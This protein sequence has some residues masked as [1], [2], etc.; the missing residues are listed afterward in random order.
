MINCEEISLA[1]PHCVS[2]TRFMQ[3]GIMYITLKLLGPQADY[4]N[5]SES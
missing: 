3:R 5:Y 2:H 1:K 4:M